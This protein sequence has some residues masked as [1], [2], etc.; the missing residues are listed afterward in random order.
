MEDLK[1]ELRKLIN[2][3]KPKVSQ[4]DSRDGYQSLKIEKGNSS[5]EFPIKEGTIAVSSSKI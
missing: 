5:F 1:K 3:N 2:K 4:G